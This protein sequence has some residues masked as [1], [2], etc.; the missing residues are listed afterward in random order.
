MLADSE[1]EVAPSIVLRSKRLILFKPRFC[2]RSKIGG[3][4]N[5]GWQRVSDCIQHLTGSL[6]RGQFSFFGF[7]R[8]KFILPALRVFATGETEP[9]VA[10]VCGGWGGVLDDLHV[11]WNRADEVGEGA[12]W[13]EYDDLWVRGRFGDGNRPGGEIED[14]YDGCDGEFDGS[15]GN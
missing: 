3:P 4:A 2:R 13:G 8:G 6:T 14:V 10:A 1:M 11:R 9:D 7:K 5:Q 12:G 15:S